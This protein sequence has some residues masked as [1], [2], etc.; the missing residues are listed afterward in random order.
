MEGIDLIN[1]QRKEENGARRQEVNRLTAAVLREKNRADE[2]E[3]QL[4]EKLQKVKLDDEQASAQESEHVAKV[5]AE[6]ARKND[7]RNEQMKQVEKMKQLSADFDEIN[8]EI[9]REDSV[10]SKIIEI[11][12]NARNAQDRI[13]E[14]VKELKSAWQSRIQQGEKFLASKLVET[15]KNLCLEREKD[16]VSAME[17]S[18][19]LE[20]KFVEEAARN[21]KLK[22][23]L[24]QLKK[25]QAELKKNKELI[26]AGNEEKRKKLAQLGEAKT[27]K[28]KKRNEID[29]TTEIVRMKLERMKKENEFKKQDIEPL[30]SAIVRKERAIQALNEDSIFYEVADLKKKSVCLEEKRDE[31]LAAIGKSED[32]KKENLKQLEELLPK[33]E[34]LKFQ[35]EGVSNRAAEFDNSIAAEKEKIL[36]LQSKE[37]ESKERIAKLKMEKIEH[38]ARI[39]ENQNKLDDSLAQIFENAPKIEAMIKNQKSHEE[40]KK[41]EEALGIREEQLRRKEKSL[42]SPAQNET[43]AGSTATGENIFSD[44]SRTEKIKK[45]R[46]EETAKKPFHDQT[47]LKKALSSP[48]T[49]KRSRAR[50]ELEELSDNS[51]LLSEDSSVTTTLQ[52]ISPS[53]R[54]SKKL[55]ETSLMQ[56]DVAPFS[57]PDSRKSGKAP[58]IFKKKKRV[59]T[60]SLERARAEPVS[61]ESPTDSVLNLY[62]QADRL[63]ITS[64]PREEN[65]IESTKPGSQESYLTPTDQLPPLGLYER[66]QGI[67]QAS[68][69]L[70]SC[71][72]VVFVKESTPVRTPTTPVAVV[73]PAKKTGSSRKSSSRQS[74]REAKK[75]RER[76]SGLPSDDSLSPLARGAFPNEPGP[77]ISDT[78]RPILKTPKKGAMRSRSNSRVSF[79]KTSLKTPKRAASSKAPLRKDTPKKDPCG[80]DIP[81]SDIDD[82]F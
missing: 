32:L 70:S 4:R 19:Q 24:E 79:S 45:P 29:E 17:K 78:P 57:K 8:E 74:F 36:T 65:A 47:N 20:S 60:S 38:L 59:R 56:T 66:S 52:L 55:V 33:E 69:M 35:L 31:L 14:E 71:S 2:K 64:P 58:I 63:R 22:K 48:L 27:M 54:A 72:S 25:Q 15:S 34:K 7:E 30:E 5:C 62:E 18:R 82:F 37:A 10:M 80:R 43:L 53:E 41:K 49:K 44:Q 21:E 39:E 12:T 6:L 1:H 40:L 46:L 13:S 26:I 77:S 73:S 28:V 42:K 3:D 61:Q 50:Q 81:A 67:K 75:F 11:C 23:E 51:H 68:E 76:N 9:L 16:Y